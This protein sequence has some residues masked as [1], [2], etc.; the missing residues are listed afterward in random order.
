MYGAII[1]DIAGSCY[2]RHPVKRKDFEMFAYRSRVTD[3]SVLT[4]A[5]AE[6]LLDVAGDDETL[7]I[8]FA[9][10]IKKWGRRYPRVGYGGRFITWLN[11]ED[12]D[13]YDSFGN[14][15]A[16]RVS[17]CGWMADTMEEVRRLAAISSIA[18][19]T[20]PEGIKG[21]ESVAAAIFMART[22]CSREEIKKYIEDEFGYDLDRT[23]DEIR[24][25]Y[26]FDVTC[27]GSV[28]EAIICFLESED[29][30][31]AI[32]SAISLGG[33]SDTQAAIAGSI[34]EAYFG[35]P[36]WL[37]Q[38]AKEFIPEDMQEVVDRFYG[39]LPSDPPS[40]RLQL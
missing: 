29:Y 11:K 23:C 34:A 14:G 13:G 24:P 6:T 15:S 19:H 12:L 17:P 38:K 7:R 8:A 25:D 39:A 10:N 22:G 9:R 3:D 18:T 28:P 27:Q 20:H 26:V 4:V 36:E 35:I 2:E 21:A 1:G 30:E 37:I 5:V 40:V 31:D 16:M 33:D 32:R